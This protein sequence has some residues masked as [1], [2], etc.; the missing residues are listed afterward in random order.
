M[1]C[2]CFAEKQS[3]VILKEQVRGNARQ[4]FAA[5]MASVRPLLQVDVKVWR[6]EGF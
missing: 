5:G 6:D 3:A 1:K 2:G 4:M